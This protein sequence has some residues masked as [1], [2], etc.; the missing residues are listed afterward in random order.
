MWLGSL[1]AR[2][3]SGARWLC[4][5]PR[6]SLEP[7]CAGFV[8]ESAVL[9]RIGRFRFRRQLHVCHRRLCQQT[10]KTPSAISLS[11]GFPTFTAPPNPANFTGTIFSQNPISSRED[12]AIQRQLRTRIAG[13]IVLTAGYA[14]SRSSHIL[15]DGNNINVGP[16]A[17]CGTVSGYTLGCGPADRHS[18]SHIPRSPIRSFKIFSTRHRPL[19]LSADQGRDQ[20]RAIWHLC[21]HR[22]YLLARQ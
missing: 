6:F 12:S 21:A 1:G 22:I 19:Q 7:G 10:G 9:R 20:K 3:Y 16:P 18:V 8:A 13:P 11:H 2:A 14:G 17:A 4:H 5:I 15:I